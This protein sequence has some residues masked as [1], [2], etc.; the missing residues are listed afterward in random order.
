[1]SS[2]ESASGNYTLA[3]VAAILALL[4]FIALISLQ[5]LELLYYRAAPTLF[6]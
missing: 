4:L 5:T 1:M 3:G 6:P 2:S